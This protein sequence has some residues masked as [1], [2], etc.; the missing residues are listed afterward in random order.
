MGL[1]FRSLA[2]L[3]RSVERRRQSYGAGAGADL[4]SED[5]DTFFPRRVAGPPGFR[6]WVEL[7]LAA[8]GLA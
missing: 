3:R 1:T 2:E 7:L 8:S 5:G 6:Q 4:L